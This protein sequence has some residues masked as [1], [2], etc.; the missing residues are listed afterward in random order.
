MQKGLVLLAA[1]VAAATFIAFGA[2]AMPAAPLKA[3]VSSSDQVVHVR[4]GCGPLR[5]RGP[6]GHC[7]RGP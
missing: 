4:G 2:Q 3:A 5:H 7:R 6:H 1:I